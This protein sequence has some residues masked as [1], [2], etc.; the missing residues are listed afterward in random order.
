MMPLLCAKVG[1]CPMKNSG[2]HLQSENTKYHRIGHFLPLL[3]VLL[4]LVLLLLNSHSQVLVYTMDPHYYYHY[5][6]YYYCYL[7]DSLIA[8]NVHR[9]KFNQYCHLFS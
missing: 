9:P 1:T 5:Y 3:S 2:W 6:Y 8:S 7:C 4:M